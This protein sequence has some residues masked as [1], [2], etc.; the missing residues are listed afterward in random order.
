MTPADTQP[1][2]WLWIEIVLFS[3]VIILI[4]TT[5]ILFLASRLIPQHKLDGLPTW[6]RWVLFL[7][8]AFLLA[9]LAEMIPRMLF[10]IV[11]VSLNHQLSFRPGFDFLVW[12][13]WAPWLFVV[14]GLLVVPISRRFAAFLVVGGLKFMVAVWNLEQVF[15]S[16]KE[17]GSWDAL[18]AAVGAPLWWDAI[19]YICCIASIV[20]YAVYLTKER[21]S[22]DNTIPSKLGEV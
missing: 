6:L 17:A 19:I 4:V 15:K 13:L 8:A 22:I 5:G 14:G 9:F 1:I 21:Q 3:S 11:E 12:Q 18:D 16:A 10:A 20:A 7:P 2:T